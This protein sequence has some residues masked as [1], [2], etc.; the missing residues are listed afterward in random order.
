MYRRIKET[1]TPQASSSN[2]VPKV[3]I[4]DFFLFLSFSIVGVGL[5]EL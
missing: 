1:M 3:G 5:L 4:Q 2:V